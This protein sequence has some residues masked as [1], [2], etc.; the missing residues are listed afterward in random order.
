MIT[1]TKIDESFL[2]GQFFIID[3][4]SPFRLG[5]DRKRGSIL[6]YVREGIPLKLLF[7]ENKIEAFFVGIN[8][9]RKKWLISCT[10]NY[11]KAVIAN[12]MVV[13]SKNVDIYNI[14]YDNLLYL[15]D[16][17]SRFEDTLVKTFIELIVSLA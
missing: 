4:S 7:I 9:H 1:K 10:Y 5:R 12:H 2:I 8:L 14:K 13:L 3:F 16:F 17:N 15:V 11:K 6:L